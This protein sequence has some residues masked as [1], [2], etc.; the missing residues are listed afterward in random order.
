M[1][2]RRFDRS[3]SLIY[4]TF[5]KW[6]VTQTADLLS[7][8]C[9]TLLHIRISTNRLPWNGVACLHVSI[10]KWKTSASQKFTFQWAARGKW[11]N[12]P[13]QRVR[14]EYTLCKHFTT[15]RT[16]C[17]V[18]IHYIFIHVNSG[19]VFNNSELIKVWLID[20]LKVTGCGN[21]LC[22]ESG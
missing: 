3:T 10:L 22:W 9:A 15:P 13:G 7:A 5:L 11:A 16:G 20:W 17:S 14:G 21:M 12:P 2:M 19:I 8:L 6:K 4:N 1:S 18:Y